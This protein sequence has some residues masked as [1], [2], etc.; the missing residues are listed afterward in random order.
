M[1]KIL[2]EES[3]WPVKRSVTIDIKAAMEAL[4]NT[5]AMLT[6]KYMPM[7]QRIVTSRLQWKLL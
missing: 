3:P 5:K 1:V 6:A 2:K 4:E 7:L